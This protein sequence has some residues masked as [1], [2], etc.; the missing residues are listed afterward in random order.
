M[1][2]EYLLSGLLAFGSN[3][4]Y[5]LKRILDGEWRFFRK[6]VHL[7]QLYRTLNG[8]EEQG[9]AT[10]IIEHRGNLP[11]LRTYTLT[12]D[13]FKALTDWLINDQSEIG[14]RFQERIFVSKVYFMGLLDEPQVII[15]QLE[16]E[17]SFRKT[18]IR[19]NRDRERYLVVSSGS[20][21]PDQEKMNW[22][23]DLVHDY[24]TGAM[25]HYVGWL[26]NTIE[27]LEKK[28]SSA[29]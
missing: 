8:M 14:F 4:G 26:S 5:E 23:S 15:K 17:L 24:G 7:S 22:F 2:L 27:E 12:Q 1:K 13:G 18:Q 28:F 10:S 3:N 20:V 11:D 6:S 16:N 19:E 29:E 21:N 9:L 25:D